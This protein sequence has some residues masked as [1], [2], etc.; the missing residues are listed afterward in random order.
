MRNA[1]LNHR[2]KK[3]L[4]TFQRPTSNGVGGSDDTKI[5]KGNIRKNQ[6]S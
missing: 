6:G 4:S 2:M 3:F 5:N 1:F